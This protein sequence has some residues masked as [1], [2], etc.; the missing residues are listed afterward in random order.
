MLMENASLCHRPADEAMLFGNLIFFVIR[1]IGAD[2]DAAEQIHIG[3]GDP[4]DFQQTRAPFA[5][6]PAQIGRQRYGIR[7][8]S[9]GIG[10]DVGLLRGNGTGAK[11]APTHHHFPTAEH[12]AKSGVDEIMT[13]TSVML[14]RHEGSVE[15][16][17]TRRRRRNFLRR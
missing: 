2:P 16:A 3:Q 4:V 1:F 12:T 15:T 8:G 6:S 10:G 7:R 13:G 5:G 14:R 11:S 9:I 17:G